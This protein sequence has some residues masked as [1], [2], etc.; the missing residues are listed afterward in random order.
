MQDWTDVRLDCPFSGGTTPRKRLARIE[1]MPTDHPSYM[2]FALARS[3]SILARRS[4]E[5]VP[6]RF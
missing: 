3:P 2:P 4:G 1:D 5:A 6:L